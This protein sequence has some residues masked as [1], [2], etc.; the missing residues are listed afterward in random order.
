MGLIA[1]GGTRRRVS[2]GSEAI[3]CFI[4]PLGEEI[5]EGWA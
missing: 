3:V 5:V 2:S 4:T 1:D